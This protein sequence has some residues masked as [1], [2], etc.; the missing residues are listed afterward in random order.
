MV[1][2]LQYPRHR[3]IQRGSLLIVDDSE[4]NRDALSR[5][6]ALKGYLVTTAGD[7][8]QALALAAAGA[9]DLV[10]LD[11]DM[12]GMTGLEV[13]SR[14][15]DTRAQTALPIIMVTGR[16]RGDDIVEAF[17]LGAND[18]VT[19]PIDFPVALA[20]IGTHLS[21]KRAVEDLRESEERYALAVRGA[22][23]GLW[24]WN[25]TTN[26]VYWSPRWKQMLG[27][28]ESAIGVSPDEWLT[29]V[30]HKDAGRVKAALAAHLADA[31]GFY[32]SEHRI[33]HRNGTFRWVLCR[34]A[35]VR[36]R[37]GAVTRLAGS[38]TDITDAKVADALTG[39]P[40][41]VLFVDLIERAIK[42][43][44]R[45]R[46]CTFALLTLG[47]DRFKAVNHSLGRLTT[48]CL[49]VAI[50]HRLQSSLRTTDAVTHQRGS[51]LARLGGDEFTVLLEDINDASDAIRVSDRLRLALGKPF[52]VDGHQVFVSATVGITVSTTGYVR[53]EDVLQDAAI[54]LHR[55]KA[56]GT[57]PYELFDPAM[58]ER[59]VSR[60]Q[61][62][63]D[64][65]NAIDNREFA[66]MYQPIISVETGKISGFEALVRWRHPT[67][68]LLGPAEFIPIAE[69][70]GMIGPIGRLVLIE[71]CRQMVA[72]QRRFGTDAPRV[73]C[74]NV[75]GKQL[76]HVDLASDIEAILKDTGL[77]A[78]GLKLE[79]TESA[80]IGDVHAAETT[81]KR[82]QSIGIEWSIDDF[83]TGYSSLSCLHRLQ[84]DTVK[85]DRSFVS[86]I[87]SADKGSEM[88]CAIVALA[89]NLGMDVV[90]EGVE[91]AEQLS[92]IEALGCEFVQGFYFS[93][94]VDVATADDLIASQ[95][96]RDCNARGSSKPLALLPP[97]PAY[98]ERVPVSQTRS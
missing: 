37:H 58:R 13:L 42:R 68:G 53:P 7:G 8:D 28:D 3:M 29:R 51:T 43:T 40:N 22:N 96:W 26:E 44:Q 48:D 90:A 33:L 65:R 98:Q 74:V 41:R 34:G 92:E 1:G 84:A 4:P 52:D 62:E 70:T 16:T 56:S 47:L 57:T 11:V 83:G 61:V 54:A 32:E 39:L 91:T 75:S 93:R 2:T 72:W 30:H 14:L 55:A 25:L 18:Y 60:L 50:A 46:D 66:V 12:P 35:A 17:R 36:D 5:W 63:T 6:L 19:K 31:S 9:Y 27:Y 64:L 23:D 77:E 24:D 67:R 71:S 94:P 59:A 49:L 85:V 79:I 15:R 78:S 10:L 73:V 89:R 21:H 80:Y 87:G 81:L 95:P 69:D 86:R 82:M 97:K 38:L 45:H 20:R 88:V 76:A